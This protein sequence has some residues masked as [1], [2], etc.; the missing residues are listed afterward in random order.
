MA[1]IIRIFLRINLPDLC[2]AF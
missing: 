2:S 1:T